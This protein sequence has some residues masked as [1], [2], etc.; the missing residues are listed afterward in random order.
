MEGQILTEHPF[1]YSIADQIRFDTISQIDAA[2]LFQLHQIKAEY[3][4]K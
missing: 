4:T 3:E 2:Y 1:D